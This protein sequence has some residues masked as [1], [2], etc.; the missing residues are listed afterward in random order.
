MMRVM[1]TFI[2]S[3]RFVCLMVALALAG[4]VAAPPHTAP[5]AV[6]VPVIYRIDPADTVHIQFRMLDSVNALRRAAAVPALGLSAELTAAAATHA[7]DMALQNR[8]WHFG[9]DGSSP[10]D[11]ARAAGYGGRVLGE[12]ISETYEAEIETIAAWM[13][14]QDTRAVLVDPMARDLGLGFFQEPSGKIWW[15]LMTGDAGVAAA[16]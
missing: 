4:C 1:M 16:R 11:R 6:G 3:F 7:R 15:A 10:I 14:R 13:G 2:R 8:P 12:T 5:A 9:S